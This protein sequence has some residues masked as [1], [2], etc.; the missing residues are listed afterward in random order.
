MTP[1]EIERFWSKV[2]KTDGC[3]LWRGTPLKTGYGQ[4]HLNYKTVR[5]HRISLQLHL[6]RD[7]LPGFDVCHSPGVCHNRLCVNP[8]HLREGTRS[9]NNADMILDGTI[10]SG[11]RHPFSKLTDDSV[12]YIRANTSESQQQ[13][14]TRFGVSRRLIQQILRGEVWKHLL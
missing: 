13:L 9:E 6:G 14:A 2:E 11:T 3:W 4:F 8:T 7:I 10:T 5:A 1:E 12:R